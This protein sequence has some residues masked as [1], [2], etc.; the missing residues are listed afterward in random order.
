MAITNEEF[1]IIEHTAAAAQTLPEALAILRAHLPHL[2]WRGCEAADIDEEPYRQYP[3]LDLHFLDCSGHC[4]KLAH[5]PA[6][7]SG[8]LLARRAAIC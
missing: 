1:A 3:G 5:E 8:V 7:A 2:R 6:A 4:L